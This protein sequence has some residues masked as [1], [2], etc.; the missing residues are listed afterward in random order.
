[1]NLFN[2]NKKDYYAQIGPDRNMHFSDVANDYCKLKRNGKYINPNNKSIKTYRMP[3]AKLLKR[4]IKFRLIKRAKQF[5]P[6]YEIELPINTLEE[7]KM[8]E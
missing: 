5:N 2:L 7:R 1:M 4:I 3:K 8:Y 6:I